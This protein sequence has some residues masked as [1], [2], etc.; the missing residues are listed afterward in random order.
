M[1]MRQWWGC[2]GRTC[3]VG[4]KGIKGLKV[5]VS[6]QCCISR[7][8]ARF[9]S[10]GI[11]PGGVRGGSHSV[12][13]CGISKR[14][15][16]VAGGGEQLQEWELPRV[17]NLE[18]ESSKH[19]KWTSVEQVQHCIDLPRL[20]TFPAHTEHGR[21]G[22]GLGWTLPFIKRRRR[23]W[24]RE[25]ERQENREKERMTSN[26]RCDVVAGTS[27]SQSVDLGFIP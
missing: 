8:R 19:F 27:T 6:R 20:I 23:M 22:P 2:R 14:S 7:G 15:R 1:S 3:K 24:R 16:N 11:E 21:R 17:L 9:N 5:K 13:R 4:G 26:N 18:K 25:T 10:V 12:G